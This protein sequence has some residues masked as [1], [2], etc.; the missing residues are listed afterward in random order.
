MVYTSK[1]L[2]HRFS[3]VCGFYL[4]LEKN[5]W[6]LESHMKYESLLYLSDKN[7]DRRN[8][9][10]ASMLLKKK[11]IYDMGRINLLSSNK[12]VKPDFT[13]LFK[14]QEIFDFFNER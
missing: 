8:N 4:E 9:C 6:I 10:L 5:L 13:F 7:L 3:N 1:S 12:R 2:R 11:Y 14:W